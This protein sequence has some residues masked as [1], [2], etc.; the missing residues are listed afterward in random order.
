MKRTLLEIYA[1]AVCFFAVACFVIVLGMAAWNGIALSAPG[2]TLSSYVWGHHQSDQAFRDYL[3]GQHRHAD[4]KDY[5][6]P[7]GTALTQARERSLALEIQSER[8]SAFQG[9]VRYVIILFIDAALFAVHWRLAGRAR[10]SP[11]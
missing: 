11:D 3:A 2:F 4:E 5:V 6:P 1:L 8:R 10:Q 9:L 7:E